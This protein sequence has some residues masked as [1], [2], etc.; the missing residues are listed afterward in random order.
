L[1][2]PKVPGFPKAKLNDLASVMRLMSSKTVGVLLEPIQG[3]SGV[4]P[5]TDNSCRSC[6]R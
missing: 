1:F 2:E 3:E 5:A 4:W 6:A